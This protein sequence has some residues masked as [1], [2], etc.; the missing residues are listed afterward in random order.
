MTTTELIIKGSFIGIGLFSLARMIYY[1][2]FRAGATAL[3][4]ELTKKNETSTQT[5]NVARKD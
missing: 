4:N 5:R 2:G 1:M 3:F